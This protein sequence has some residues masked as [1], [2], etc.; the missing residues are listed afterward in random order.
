MAESEKEEV[1]VHC[2]IKENAELI[3]KILDADSKNKEYDP[4]KGIVLK[5]F[6]RAVKS[7]FEVDK[8]GKREIDKIIN[9][10]KGESK[11]NLKE[12]KSLY[13]KNPEDFLRL[14]WVVQL[15]SK[16][17]SHDLLRDLIAIMVT[18]EKEVLKDERA[19]K[20]DA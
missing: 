7:I 17:Y 1:V 14:N 5:S 19:K 10:A 20:S 4:Y 13:D 16:F 3:S 6:K 11:R 18:V 15:N 8:Y 2:N 12:L 9:V